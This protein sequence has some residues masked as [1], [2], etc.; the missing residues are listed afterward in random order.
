LLTMN[1]P[2]SAQRRA[3]E[4]ARDFGGTR[5]M[6]KKHICGTSDG[7]RQWQADCGVHD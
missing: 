6:K 3:K 4:R 2:I 5:D 7:H 1:S